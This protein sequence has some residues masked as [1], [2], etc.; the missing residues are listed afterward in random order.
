MRGMPEFRHQP[1]M[2]PLPR[3]GNAG[4]THWV[5]CV[6]GL[7]GRRSRRAS[8]P[9]GTFAR[10]C[11]GLGLTTTVP[12]NAAVREL[13]ARLMPIRNCNALRPAARAFQAPAEGATMCGVL[14]HGTAS[15][16]ERPCRRPADNCLDAPS[17]GAGKAAASSRQA[18]PLR[19]A[20]VVTTGELA[21]LGSDDAVRLWMHDSETGSVRGFS[22]LGDG[23]PK[24]AGKCQRA[25]SEFFHPSAKN[26]LPPS[27]CNLFARQ[28]WNP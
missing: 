18:L 25:K 4:G 16:P 26:V 23:V 13:P 7:H 15:A 6:P 1:G 20:G 8:G 14:P 27:V 2:R 9:G 12:C 22:G 3:P 10:E 5:V 28:N 17:R 21:S 11:L 19:R 24:S